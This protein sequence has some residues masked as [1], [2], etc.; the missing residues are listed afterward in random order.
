MKTIDLIKLLGTKDQ[1]QEVE[2]LV[3]DK[4][5][6]AIVVMDI[7]DETADLGKLFKAFRTKKKVPPNAKELR[8]RRGL[9][10][11]APCCEAIALDTKPAESAINRVKAHALREAADEF[12]KRWTVAGKVQEVLHIMANELENK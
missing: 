2:F 5:T 3:V 4:S 12:G 10:V 8:M 1:Q 7:T 11:T 9:T 6:T